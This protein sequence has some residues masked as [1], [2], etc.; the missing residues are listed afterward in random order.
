MKYYYI[1]ILYNIYKTTKTWYFSCSYFTYLYYIIY[2]KKEIN[3][4]FIII[5]LH[6]KN[7][8]SYGTILYLLLIPFSIF[9]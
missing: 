6:K 9:S 2:T 5:I 8:T 7:S 4:D 1:S 3:K